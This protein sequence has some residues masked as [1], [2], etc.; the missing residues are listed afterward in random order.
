MT[1]TYTKNWCVKITPENREIVKSYLYV[2]N[3]SYSLGAYYGIDRFGNKV[4]SS[5]QE[6]VSYKLLTMDEFLTMVNGN[7]DNYE[8]Y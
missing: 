3:Y 2:R 5:I 7:Q 6:Q 1:M 8:I 4:G